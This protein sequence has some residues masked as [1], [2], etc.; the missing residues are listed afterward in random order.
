MATGEL[1]QP[2]AGS[3]PTNGAA[4][5]VLTRP[6]GLLAELT[7]R[8]PLGCPY[9]SNPLALD[10]REGELDIATWLRVLREAAEL[11]V[12]QVHLSGG[13]PGARRDL[14]DITAGAHAAGLYTNLIT[15]AVG[16]TESVLTGLVQAG[17]DHVQISIQDGDAQSAD[18]IAGYAG[19]FA[20]KRALAA[21][22]VGHK[23]PL[24]VNAV[25][26]RANIDRIGDIVDLSLALAANRVEIAHV[27]YYGWALRH[28]AAL[29]P[30][31]EQ[32]DRA[33]SAVADLRARQQARIVI[34]AVVPDYY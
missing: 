15:S 5:P 21:A 26:H 13:E 20:R 11:G 17:L 3:H 22:V 23:L 29:M 10:P 2:V 25:V 31:R 9:C 6:I 32:V 4:E 18:R 28:R 33:A 16:I 19:A 7:H 30:S 14:I 27:Q 24:T 34:D 8:C 1:D 12:L